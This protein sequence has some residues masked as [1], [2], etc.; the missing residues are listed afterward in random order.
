MF[1]PQWSAAKRLEE[2]FGDFVH[3][4]EQNNS[5]KEY[6]RHPFGMDYST[7]VL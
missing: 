1:V 2:W 5:A 7:I 4:T 3:G 6:L